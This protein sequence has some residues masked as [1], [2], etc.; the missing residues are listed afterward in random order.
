MIGATTGSS[1][2]GAAGAWNA[3]GYF[4]LNE[5]MSSSAST[6]LALIMMRSDSRTATPSEMNSTSGPEAS[7]PIVAFIAYW[8]MWASLAE[9]SEKSG[10]PYDADVPSRVC[11]EMYKRSTSSGMGY[12]SMRMPEYSRRNC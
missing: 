10:Y 1:G 11:A 6:L 4:S 7:G 12:G 8:K 2:S 3:N 9:T 5:L